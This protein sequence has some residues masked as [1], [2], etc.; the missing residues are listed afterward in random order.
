MGFLRTA[1]KV[2]TRAVLAADA[3]GHRSEE[4]K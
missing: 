4:N 3:K 1:T 2:A